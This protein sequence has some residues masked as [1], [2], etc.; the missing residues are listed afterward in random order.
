MGAALMSAVVGG[1]AYG[2]ATQ[3]Y[4]KQAST[5]REV[6]NDVCLSGLSAG[7]PTSPKD[8]AGIIRLERLARVCHFA[9]TGEQI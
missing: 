9:E 5:L 2:T 8:E 3:Q 6:A 1:L 4:E 7:P